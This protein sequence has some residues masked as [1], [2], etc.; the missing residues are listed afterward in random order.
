M[1]LHRLHS[2]ALILRIFAALMPVMTLALLHAIPTLAMD[3]DRYQRQVEMESGYVQSGLASIE[4]WEGLLADTENPLAGIDR[5]VVVES[6]L[7]EL[8]R[9]LEVDKLPAAKQHL[10]R[11]LHREGPEFARFA[12]HPSGSLSANV[13]RLKLRN[14][15][16]DK[17]T[18][19][20]F[21]FE[22][23]S[24]VQ[25]RSGG[26]SG[27]EL[28]TTDGASWQLE[29]LTPQHSLYSNLKRMQGQFRM[30]EILPPGATV[31]F[32]LILDRPGVT[33]QDIAYFLLSFGPWR[34]V[35]K[36][37]DNI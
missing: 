18:I 7:E 4:R 16:F 34:I 29:E 8:T 25:L 33:E 30:P 28:F 13:T 3:S 5:R 9:L 2:R 32:E 24:P 17:H 19:F 10:L 37:Y 23:R 14:P 35:I 21:R 20:L 31:S 15:A 36:F 12:F 1:P 6:L 26:K 22:N 11:L 27:C